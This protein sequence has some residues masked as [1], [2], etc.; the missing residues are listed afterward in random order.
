MHERA[1]MVDLM[2]KIEVEALAAG[3]GRVTRVRVRLGALSHLTAEHFREHF[4]MRPEGPL[5]RARRSRPIYGPT[6]PNR[7]HRLVLESID[8]ELDERLASVELDD[9]AGARP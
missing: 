3:G 7:R 5:P 1:L 8:V 2:R 6:R 4:E 9:H